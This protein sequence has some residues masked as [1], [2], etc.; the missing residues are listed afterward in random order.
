MNKDA[1][2]RKPRKENA[3]RELRK[4]GTSKCSKCHM[5]PSEK[6][7]AKSEDVFVLLVALSYYFFV[8]LSHAWTTFSRGRLPAAR[9]FAF[10][11][12][13]EGKIFSRAIVIFQKVLLIIFLIILFSRN[14]ASFRNHGYT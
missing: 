9:S 1:G 5:L 13:R 12:M 2:W 4:N 10:E 6:N 11:R 14:Q 8:S 7:V 3:L